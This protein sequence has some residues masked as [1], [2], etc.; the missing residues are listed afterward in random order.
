MV[1][2]TNQI[3]TILCRAG[4]RIR[5]CRTIVKCDVGDVM[6]APQLLEHLVSADLPAFIDGMKQ[7]RFQPKNAH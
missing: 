5:I 4:A 1:G 6:V 2:Y 3:V 7:F